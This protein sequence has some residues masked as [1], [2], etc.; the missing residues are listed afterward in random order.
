MQFLISSSQFGIKLFN[1]DRYI[2]VLLVSFSGFYI[3]KLAI[4]P[5]YISVLLA[6]FI[7]STKIMYLK[8]L[9]FYPDVVFRASVCCL[10]YFLASQLFLKPD[11]STLVNCLFSLFIFVV[12][13]QIACKISMSHI[14]FASEKL[15]IFS[16][17]LL[18]F[19][20][21][22]RLSN[23]IKFV[24]FSVIGRSELE[25]YYYKI[26][27]IM[28]VDSNF[29]G[30]FI[31][32]LFTFL[33][34]LKEITKKK[35]PFV[36]LILT[37]LTI[38]TLSRASII[39]LILFSI[40]YRIGNVIYSSKKTFIILA[41]IIALGLLIPLHSG[42]ML[43]DDSLK[44]KFELI[45]QAYQFILNSSAK[46]LLFGVGFGN[47]INT[48]GIGAHNFFV[49]YLVESGLIGLVMILFLWILILIKTKLKAGIVMFP[50]LLNGL[51]LSTVAIPYLYVM[52]AII[53]ALEK[54]MGNFEG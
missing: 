10:S 13:Y 7:Y 47:A 38:L 39:T 9:N 15:V 36:F 50:F 49:I 18:I 2:F 5:I 16:L 1:I 28:Y 20:A 25:F 30:L 53:L 11:I 17:P 35:Y 26:N 51:S 34:Y 22:Y 21:A 3:T 43:D 8:K 19:E 46:E 23:P 52:F 41:I 14:L 48:M 42:Y 12:T 4:S 40:I 24:D 45:V 6:L 54:R 32:S 44:T 27:S 37:I 31:I 33:V 29:V